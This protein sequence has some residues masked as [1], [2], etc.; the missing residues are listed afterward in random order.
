MNMATNT[1]QQARVKQSWPNLTDPR[2]LPPG[3]M[4]VYVRTMHGTQTGVEASP[5][6]TFGE[7][8]AGLVWRNPPAAMPSSRLT[9]DGRV[10]EDPCRTLSEHGVQDSTKVA[11]SLLPGARK[12]KGAQQRKPVHERV[13]A[14]AVRLRAVM[15]GRNGA[16]EV[17]FAT[18]EPAAEAAA[19]AD[20]ELDLDL[21]GLLGDRSPQVEVKAEEPETCGPGD[22]AGG[23]AGG[24]GG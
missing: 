1:E 20:L 23:R 18:P 4:L 14:E 16:A 22:R 21:W 11:V 15:D 17:D 12:P 6:A 2:A 10:L 8:Q 5:A 3:A 9:V 7:F 24:R 19:M 13:V